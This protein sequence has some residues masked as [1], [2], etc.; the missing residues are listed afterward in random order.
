MKR[1]L[2]FAVVAPPLGF[3]VGFWMLLQIANWTVGAPSSFD[4]RQAALLPT[5]Y[6]VGVIPALL[7]AWFDHVLDR[8]N[9]S[10][11]IALTGLFGYAVTYLPLLVGAYWKS[12]FLLDPG[13]PLIGLIGAVPA[14]L[15][16]WLATARRKQVA[17]A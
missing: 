3:V 8:R 15:C 12:F 4:L 11:R 7:A 10:W 13:L 16:A 9:V 2:V 6:L 5:V 1:F 17:G 14:A